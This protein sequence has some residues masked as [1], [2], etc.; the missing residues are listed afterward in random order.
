CWELNLD[1]LTWTRVNAPGAPA[2][3]RAYHMAVFDPRSD[4]FFITG[5]RGL[6][7]SWKDV[8]SLGF[9]PPTFAPSSWDSLPTIGPAPEADQG[10]FAVDAKDQLFE[11]GGK[12]V[13]FTGETNDMYSIDLSILG[14]TRLDTVP[15]DR[16]DQVSFI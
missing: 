15:E 6:R 3:G 16:C 9:T 5:G 11:I 14:W 13:L 4:Q 2:E 8:R 7:G 1:N 10:T 12:S